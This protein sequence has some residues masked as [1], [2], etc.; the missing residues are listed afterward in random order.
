MKSKRQAFLLIWFHLIWLFDLVRALVFLTDS[1]MLPHNLVGIFLF[2]K[3]ASRVLSSTIIRM[4]IK[5]WQRLRVSTERTYNFLLFWV[6]GLPFFLLYL[7]LL[8]WKL[9]KWNSSFPFRHYL[10]LLLLFKTLNC[11]TF[12]I[13]L[14]TAHRVYSIV[15]LWNSC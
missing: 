1:F 15:L 6:L 14:S 13:F 11:L 5:I 7:R 3:L 2:T 12:V 9:G 10:L 8:L 4:S